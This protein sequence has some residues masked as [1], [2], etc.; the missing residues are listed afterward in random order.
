MTWRIPSMREM[1]ANASATYGEQFDR[2]DRKVVRG[3][4]PIVMEQIPCR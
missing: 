4:L 1:M 2:V 3:I